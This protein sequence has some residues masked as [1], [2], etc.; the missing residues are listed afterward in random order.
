MIRKKNVVQEK[1]TN[2]NYLQ[3]NVGLAH[4]QGMLNKPWFYCAWFRR[5]CTWFL[6]H[7]QG[8]LNNLWFYCTWF[9]RALQMVLRPCA[10][11]P[12]QPMVVGGPCI[13]F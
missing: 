5:L 10:R 13:W 2:L 12:K 7:V 6:N 8:L 4:V 3:K 9:R 11:P 1:N